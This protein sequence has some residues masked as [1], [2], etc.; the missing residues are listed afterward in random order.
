MAYHHKQTG[1][2]T[3]AGIGIA[4]LFALLYLWKTQHPGPVELGVLICLVLVLI[5][6]SS[7]TVEVRSNTITC[8]FGL[9]LIKKTFVLSDIQSVHVVRN[10]WYA[11]WGIRW[12][13]GRYVLWN[14]SGFQAVELVLKDGNRF[15]IGTDEPEALLDAIR[16][17]HTIGI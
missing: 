13:P 2:I 1:T 14:V 4:F 8:R 16:S 10:P 15:R 7:L 12:R 11:G 17:H 6:F 5:L 9:G 3:I